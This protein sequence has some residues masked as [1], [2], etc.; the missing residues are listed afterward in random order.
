MAKRNELPALAAS[1][2][3]TV[4]VLGGGVWWLKGQFNGTGSASDTG[5]SAQV[6]SGK[7][8]IAGA[9][10]SSGR[11]ILSEKVST[12]KQNGLDAL[13]KGDY[14]TAQTEFAAALKE[15]RN[16]PESL[17]YLNNA[18]IG[19]SKAYS[20]AMS[21]PAGSNLNSALEIMRGVAQAQSDINEAGGIGSRPVKI[22]VVDD[23]D[24]KET[25]AAIATDLVNDKAVLGV[26]G[27]Y[28]SDT[29]LAA[30]EKYEA[31]QLTMISPTSTAVKIADAGDYIFRTVPS[32]RLAAAVLAR[33]VLNEINK[34]QA[35]VFYTSKSAYSNSV[36]TEFTTELLSNGGKV[37]ADFDVSESSFSAGQALKTAKEAG[38]EVIMLAL[39][40]DTLD[41]AL[42]VISVNQKELPMVGGDSLY[43]PKILDIGQANAKG[44]TVAVPWHIL[45]H[46][47]SPFAQESRQLWGGNVSWR[48]A[49]AYDAV[50]VLA[51]AI[52]E[53]P[54]REGVQAALA[55]SGFSAQ[56]ATDTVSFFPSGDRNQPSQ[57]VE[58]VKGSAAGGD[59]TYEPV[60]V[61]G[62]ESVSHWSIVGPLAP[63]N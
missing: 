54:T 52:D 45:S 48:T 57:L 38:A 7:T 19:N 49:M 42:Q 10:G 34:K 6:A 25:A 20:I 30:A 14:A 51:A 26:V 17:I 22:L 58:V 43:D 5:N 29:T 13:A 9:D 40:A 50:K 41:T 16:D 27:H 2:L 18:K 8:G 28:S 46:E 61:V 11:S 36:K 32:D 4:A 12:A 37:V 35:V 55:A 59:Y 15:N 33:H 39:N 63:V 44:L 21:V 1:L 53:N 23:S 62:Q 60:P 47:Q 24:N 56:G 3:I 31:G